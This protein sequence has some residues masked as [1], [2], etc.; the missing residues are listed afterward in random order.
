MPNQGW[1]EVSDRIGRTIGSE[2]KRWVVDR[3]VEFVA[4][5][6]CR[7]GFALTHDFTS[8]QMAGRRVACL[9]VGSDGDVRVRVLSE[10]N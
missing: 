10:K 6:G 2:G 8:V 4:D 3:T 1:G 5:G 9:L 7:A